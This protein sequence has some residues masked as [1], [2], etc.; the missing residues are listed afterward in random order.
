MYARLAEMTTRRMREL[1]GA[2]R[3]PMITFC[4]VSENGE[5]GTRLELFVAGVAEN[6]ETLVLLTG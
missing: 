6:A 5:E 3:S 2:I 1:P 4:F